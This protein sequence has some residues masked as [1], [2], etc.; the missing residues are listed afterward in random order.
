MRD[1]K[2][3]GVDV[4]VETCPQYLLMTSEQMKTMHGLAKVNPPIREPGHDVALW[5]ALHDGTIDMIATDHAPHAIEEK[6][7]DTIWN[8]E[9]GFPGVQTQMALMLTQVVRGRL[10]IND[11]VKWACVNPARAWG[12]YPHKGVLQPGAD[13]DIVLVDMALE[14]EIRDESLFSKSKISPWHGWRTSAGPVLTMVRGKVVA[15]DGELVGERGWGRSIKASQVM[16]AAHPRHVEHSTAA[17][18]NDRP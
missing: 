16:P 18:V 8:C 5:A 17:I 12:L 4:T 7:R 14:R 2:R 1:A 11:Y 3:R 6:R 15:K 13:A 10:T 9:C